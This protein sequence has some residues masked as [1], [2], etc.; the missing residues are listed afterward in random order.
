MD[1][2]EGVQ[3]VG[4]VSA[5]RVNRQFGDALPGLLIAQDVSH[6]HYVID[7][8]RTFEEAKAKQAEEEAKKKQS[9]GEPIQEAHAEPGTNAPAI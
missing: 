2:V 3:F 7:S 6:A 5:Y 8:I 4:I 9:E 1:P